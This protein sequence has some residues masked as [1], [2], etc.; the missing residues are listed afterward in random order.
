MSTLYTKFES[1]IILSNQ[2]E[3]LDGKFFRYFC[4]NDYEWVRN[5]TKPI[6][7]EKY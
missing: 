4:N 3:S 1:F 6:I 5:D 7:R 2:I